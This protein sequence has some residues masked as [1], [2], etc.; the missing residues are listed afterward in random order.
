MC[1][2]DVFV[3][4]CLQA[5]PRTNIREQSRLDVLAQRD[6]HVIGDRILTHFVVCQPN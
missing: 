1:V 6:V 3:V 4:T 2:T 5:A